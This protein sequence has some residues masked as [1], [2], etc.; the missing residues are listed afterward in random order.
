MA[1]IRPQ[2]LLNPNNE[3]VA[4]DKR[5]ADETKSGPVLTDK[6]C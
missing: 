4:R 1:D 5:H 6:L 3:C 2:L